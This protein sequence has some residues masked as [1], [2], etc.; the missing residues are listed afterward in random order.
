MDTSGYEKLGSDGGESTNDITS[1]SRDSRSDLSSEVFPT[2]SL[3]HK[4]NSV[5]S[6]INNTMK[7]LTTKSIRNTPGTG[8]SVPSVTKRPLKV[9]ISTPLNTNASPKQVNSKSDS[10]SSLA[11]KVPPPRP[12]PPVASKPAIKPKP[13]A[14]ANQT[15]T[16]QPQPRLKLHSYSAG[17]IN[18]VDTEHN[19]KIIATHS[20]SKQKVVPVK[21]TP[22]RP[23]IRK[24]SS[25]SNCFEKGGT[26]KP[27]SSPIF[28]PRKLSNVREENEDKESSL[29]KTST[30]HSTPARFSPTP[31]PQLLPTKLPVTT[32]KRLNPNLPPKPKSSPRS[33]Q[34]QRN[35]N[36]IITLPH[37]EY[38]SSLPSSPL[39]IKRKPLPPQ[40]PTLL[41]KRHGLIQSYSEGN[42]LS[43]T[44]RNPLLDITPPEKPHTKRRPYRQVVSVP[45]Q[46][47]QTPDASPSITPSVSPPIL[48]PRS[49]VLP[50]QE[51]N[52]QS[53]SSLSSTLTTAPRTS[54]ST[55][56]SQE[57]VPPVPLRRGGDKRSGAVSPNTTSTIPDIDCQTPPPL[58]LVSRKL[59]S[60]ERD[61]TSSDTPTV[62]SKKSIKSSPRRRPPSPPLSPSPPPIPAHHTKTIGCSS[63]TNTSTTDLTSLKRHS[64]F[65]DELSSTQINNISQT[66]EVFK[67]NSQENIDLEK[68]YQ[69]SLLTTS[70][71]T[72][73]DKVP[74]PAPSRKQRST[75]YELTFL[76]PDKQP[77][78]ISESGSTVSSDDLPPPLP[79]QPIP[80]KKDRQQTLLKRGPIK[81][82]DSTSP[83]SQRS[84]EGTKSD[85]QSVSSEYSVLSHQSP[86]ISDTTNTAASSK[87]KSSGIFKK[88]MI[89]KDSNDSIQSS[90][91]DLSSEM[92][93]RRETKSFSS[94]MFRR[95]NSDRFKKNKLLPPT[96]AVGCGNAFNMARKSLHRTPSVDK[97]D[98]R[99]ER[100]IRQ[101]VPK[102][103]GETS[104]SEDEEEDDEIISSPT[105]IGN[106]MLSP[107]L[108]IKSLVCVCVCVCVC[109]YRSSTATTASIYGVSQA[110]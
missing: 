9:S 96:K 92:S 38:A 83:P 88:K 98:D 22:Q 61:I 52:T 41:T 43:S 24:A 101:S 73:Q 81:A 100:S 71:V 109:H 74:S 17:D 3:K 12:K 90:N 53:A 49:P 14:L 104:S 67:S 95:S 18:S 55:S 78:I 30:K 6:E 11:S 66:Y 75:H 62:T 87:T 20:K 8:T 19:K 31:R 64:L 13:S 2:S 72:E 85:S 5:P 7:K 39:V 29:E 25:E 48:P 44:P 47:G 97:L 94:F 42:L 45:T 91:P 58:S 56:S 15:K 1:L 26:T 37:S 107:I 46:I 4:S 89:R 108:Y 36:D 65:N 57:E 80:K 23:S 86:I 102:M 110:T 79:S 105:N 84:E 51:M 21:S 59:K 103:E 40:K 28:V 50:R 99:M 60:I 16:P 93:F 33:P 77:Q 76:N 70:K 34:I 35:N 54:S 63:L 69:Q 32:T 106:I 10:R 27:P 68:L 82:R